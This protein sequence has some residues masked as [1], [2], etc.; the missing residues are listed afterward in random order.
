M[1]TDSVTTPCRPVLD[2]SS[3]TRKRPDG[4]GGRCLNDL[5]VKGSVN[6]LDLLRLVLRWQIGSYA[7]NGDLSQYYNSFKLDSKQWNLQRFL[8]KNDLDPAAEVKEGVI[9]TLI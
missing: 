2:A 4:S 8:W 6:C 9:T 3:R 5:V 1:F 7:L